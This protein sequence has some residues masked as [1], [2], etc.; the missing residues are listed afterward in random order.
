MTIR[1]F[2]IDHVHFNVLRI[3]RF[4][5]I[6]EQLFGADIT[7]ISQL[8]QLG[9]YNACVHFPAEGMTPS[10][11]DVFQPGGDSDQA[12][13]HIRDHGQGISHVAFRVENIE[14]AAVHAANCGLRELSR[15]G[16]R[17][18]KQVQF[19]TRAEL[20]FLLEFVEY[21]PGFAEDL[22]RVKERLR[23]GETVD[24]LRYVSP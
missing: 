13:E 14:D 15:L 20:G 22:A 16:Y 3:R 8:A 21:E 11:L 6:M 23:A 5:E 1:T 12:A 9:A 7:P 24:G 10:F 4:L 19:D 17:G 2:G 18:M